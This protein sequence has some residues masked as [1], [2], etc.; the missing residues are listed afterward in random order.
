[1][2]AA[3]AS[4]IAGTPSATSASGFGTA[5]SAGADRAVVAAKAT[6]SRIERNGNSF[7]NNNGGA[8]PDRAY[9]GKVSGAAASAA[10]A[11]A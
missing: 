9:L 7:C 4:G 2:V 11:F 8:M 3:S 1:M 5:A 10:W 6:A